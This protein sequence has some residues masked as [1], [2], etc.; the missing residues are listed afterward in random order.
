MTLLFLKIK[1]P[2]SLLRLHVIHEGLCTYSVFAN[3]LY[4]FFLYRLMSLTINETS[5]E[6]LEF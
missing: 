3:V 4:L 6:P 2:G 5:R 1:S